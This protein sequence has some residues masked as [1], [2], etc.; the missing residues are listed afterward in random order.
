[1]S[2]GVAAF[3]KSISS[4]QGKQVLIKMLDRMPTFF[5][6]CLWAFAVLCPINVGASSIPIGDAVE[7]KSPENTQKIKSAK[8]I[9]SVV[10]ADK[11]GSDNS[12]PTKVNSL[13]DIIE[14]KIAPAVINISITQKVDP[15]KNQLAPNSVENPWDLFRY[16]FLPDHAKKVLGSGFIIDSSGYIVTNYHVIKDAET[17]SVTLRSNNIDKTFKAKIIGIDKKTDIALLKIESKTVL[18]FLEFADSDKARVGDS[19]IAIGN[20]FG[21]GGTVTHGIISAKGRSLNTSTVDEYMQIDASINTGNSGGPVA[22]MGG[23]VLG[24]STLIYSPSGGSVGV[25]FAIPSNTIK[26]VVRQLRE[27]G[28]VER[29]WLGVKIQPVT[30]DIA[31]SIG[32]DKVTG[33]FVIEV[34]P[35][36]PA[37][38]AKIQAGDQ[39]IKYD[40][41]DVNEANKLRRMVSETP[42]NKKV[43]ISVVR[44][45]KNIDL[46]AVIEKPKTE[47]PFSLDGESEEETDDRHKE[48]DIYGMRLR[49]LDA[50]LEK[51]YGV[52][53]K[54]KNG[55]L[56]LDVKSTSL[57]ALSGILSGDIICAV[58]TKDVS[59]VDAIRKAL[60]EAKKNGKNMALLRIQRDNRT[61]FVV[62][63][64]EE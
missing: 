27:T 15:S 57:A 58:N 25:G 36:S 32:A 6:G 62:I 14:F 61:L 43:K 64:L 35:E 60:D 34:V 40:D 26:S 31:D 30:Q 17:V 59:T 10:A 37:E 46:Y 19:V 51:K 12:N 56:V 63:P 55:V 16:F 47:D 33:A 41:K 23:E 50:N 22:N 29:G 13:P 11:L 49:D 44:D 3:Y 28:S 42:V 24:M 38:K 45:A 5:I 52:K 1:M 53:G 21:L 54:N 4:G 8:D 48:K 18:P 2:V 7:T 39:I 20:P 9:S